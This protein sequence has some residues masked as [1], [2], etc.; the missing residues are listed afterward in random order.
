MI[1][2]NLI[3]SEY[4]CGYGCRVLNSKIIVC[5]I[6]EVTASG[7]VVNKSFKNEDYLVQY[8]R[9]ESYRIRYSLKSI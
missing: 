7:S 3:V 2:L 9:V 6:P 5:R 8:I 4:V 1:R